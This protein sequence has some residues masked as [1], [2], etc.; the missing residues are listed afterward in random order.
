MKTKAAQPARARGF[1]LVRDPRGVPKIDDWD[2]L[3]APIKHL[4][5][6]EI[7]DGRYTRDD[8]AQRDRGSRR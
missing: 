1:A 6:K 8:I 3:P 7:T 4:I 2:A 5:N